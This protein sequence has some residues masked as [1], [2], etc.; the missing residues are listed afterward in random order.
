MTSRWLFCQGQTGP[1]EWGHNDCSGRHAVHF[2][3]TG[4]I[5]CSCTRAPT[6]YF[7]I[8]FWRAHH[9]TLT[10]DPRGVLQ[11]PVTG[12]CY[13]D[14]IVMDSRSWQWMALEVHIWL[15]VRG[16]VHR[17]SC[18]CC[19]LQACFQLMPQCDDITRFGQH[20]K[21]TLPHLEYAGMYLQNGNA[22]FFIAQ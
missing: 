18:H 12:S 20:C 4:N 7:W 2:W 3:G 1:Q 5:S 21:D 11:D 22:V 15:S 6:W 17:A 19:S 9:S 8:R 14:I 16:C 13:N 10:T